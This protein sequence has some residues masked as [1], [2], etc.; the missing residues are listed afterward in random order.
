[1][2]LSVIRPMPNIPE[3]AVDTIL[4]LAVI[5]AGCVVFAALYIA[6]AVLSL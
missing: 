3:W 1:M 4:I 2:G 6:R 5:V